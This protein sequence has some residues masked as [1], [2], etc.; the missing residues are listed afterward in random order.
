MLVAT[1]AFA[2]LFLGS[3]VA[4]GNTPDPGD[5]GKQVAQWFRDNGS[6]V[7][8][9]VWLLTIA[10]PLFAVVAAF[11]RS[12][13]PPV[14]RDVF[15][16]GAIT[17]I[18]ETVVQSWILAGLAWHADDLA[19]R[20]ARTLLDV[21]SYWG[22]VLTSSTIMMLAPVTILAW[23][24]R[25]QLPRWLGVLAGIALLEQ[26]VETVTIFGHDGFIAPGGPMNLVLGAL[27]T[28]IAL[29]ALAIVVARSPEMRR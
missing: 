16:I 28:S 21:A 13:L 10:L 26:A 1:A 4:L 9:S 27:L 20:T 18:A 25:A 29:V 22:P 23:R 17:L 15:F 11:I 5:S 6:H 7:R 14:Y 3:T 8:W 2:V 24:R 19:P 12:H